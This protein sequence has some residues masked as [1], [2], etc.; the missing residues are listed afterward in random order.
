MVPSVLTG[1]GMTACMEGTVLQLQMM[2]SDIVVGQF[3]DENCQCDDG[4]G[5]GSPQ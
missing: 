2:V 3:V 1:F 5:C 4:S